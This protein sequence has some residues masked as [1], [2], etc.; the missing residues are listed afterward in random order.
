[1]HIFFNSRFWDSINKPDVEHLR[2]SSR[3]EEWIKRDLENWKKGRR[4]KKK[5]LMKKYGS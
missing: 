5:E 2:A 4:E 1:M 3:P